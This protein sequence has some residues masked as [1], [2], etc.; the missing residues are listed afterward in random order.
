MLQDEN[1]AHDE[2]LE[3][4][5]RQSAFPLPGEARR[6]EMEEQGEEEL[7]VGP[8]QAVPEAQG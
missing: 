5:P 6:E 2:C 3:V 8:P 7:M 1:P 4:P